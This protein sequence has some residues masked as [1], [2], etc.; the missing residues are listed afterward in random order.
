MGSVKDI[1]DLLSKLLKSVQD[2]ELAD[3][4][5]NIQALVSTFQ[6]DYLS[7]KEENLDLRKDIT[8]LN[9]QLLKSVHVRSQLEIENKELKAEN[10]ALKREKSAIPF[11]VEEIQTTQSDKKILSFDNKMGLFQ[12]ESG[13]FYCPLCL[14]NR[15]VES[16]LIEFGTGWKCTA[17]NEIFHDPDRWLDIN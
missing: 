13:Q 16:P 8:A 11:P 12:D 9:D 17:C 10:D 5:F 2:R 14:G 1:N 15:N 7:T 6:T 3:K 4:I